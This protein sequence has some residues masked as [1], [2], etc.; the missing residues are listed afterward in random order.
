MTYL[1]IVNE[2]LIRL[3]EREVSTVDQTTYSKMVGRFV[4]DAKS[5]VEK[6][7]DWNALRQIITVTTADGTKTYS[8]TGFGQ[9]GKVLSAWNDSSNY[10]IKNVEQRWM[11]RKNYVSD[12]VSGSVTHYTFR[13]E[14]AS[15][16][17]VVEVYPTPNSV[18]TLEFNC[19]VPQAD[20]AADGTAITIP[21]R[22]VVLLAVA[23][24]AE[25]KGEAGGASSARY[26]EMA[27]KE[28]SDAIARDER[29]HTFENVWEAV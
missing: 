2:V 9:D 27:D 18:E 5:A 24:L 23:M 6:M 12:T 8:L 11:D 14:D 21:W 25:E 16:D 4:N 3:R 28:V 10:M 17:S 29:K 20:L 22:P 26:F 1:E 15:D 13:G 7:W 19:V